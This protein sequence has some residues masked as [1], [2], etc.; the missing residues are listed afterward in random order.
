MTGTPKP[1]LAYRRSRLGGL[2]LHYDPDHPKVVAARRELETANLADHVAKV[3]AGWPPLT[4]EQLDRIAALLRT[5][6]RGGDDAT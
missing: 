4:D 1:E 6:G 2:A 5:G 3:L